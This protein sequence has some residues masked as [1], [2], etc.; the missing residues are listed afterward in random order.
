MPIAIQCPSCSTNLKVPDNLA[1]RAVKCPKCATV[2]KVP[3]GGAAPALTTAKTKPDR[4]AQAEGPPKKAP[5]PA[6]PRKPVEDED[7]E[8]GKAPAP[9]KAKAR[10]RDEEED[11]DRPSPKKKR[12]QDEDEDDRPSSKKA[13]RKGD[14]EDEDEDE[15]PRRK[16]AEDDGEWDPSNP[17]SILDTCDVPDAMR[18]KV[19]RELSGSEELI[20]IGQPEPNLLFKRAL[21]PAGGLLFFGL[22]F[23]GIPGGIFLS[24]DKQPMLLIFVG[25][26][27]CMIVASIVMPFW[28]KM[29]G[30]KTCYALTNRRC[31][32]WQANFF[33]MVKMTN[34]NPSQLTGMRRADSWWLSGAGDVIFKTVTIITTTH[35]RN[36]RTGGYA[37]S[38]TSSRTYYYGFLAIP[39][40]RAVETLIR[41]VLVEPYLDKQSG[42]DDDDDDRPRSRKRAK[43]DEDDEDDRPRSKKRSK[44]DEDDEDDRP[45]AKKRAKDDE[46]DEDDRPRAKKRARDD[47]DEDV[48]RTNRRRN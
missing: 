48:K 4:P 28:Q 24:K 30:H 26:G 47:D 35:Y 12:R 16:G 11:E 14:D 17:D 27:L 40:V 45:R 3:A 7:E 38:S 5:A 42:D 18:T 13:R 29:N 39:N 19:E 34:Y 23:G 37:G 46:D 31:I 33:G 15:K 21:A 2:M 6:K 9:A 20:W 44:Y 25:V 36:S 22:L 8:N 43:Y 10:P 32:V 41:E 1:G